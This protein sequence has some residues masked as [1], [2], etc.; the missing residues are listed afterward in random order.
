M[1]IAIAIIGGIIVIACLGAAAMW[2]N[3]VFS[4]PGN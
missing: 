3:K 2:L 4:S 1:K